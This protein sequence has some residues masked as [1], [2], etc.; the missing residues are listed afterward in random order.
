[1][2]SR[3]LRRVVI[4]SGVALFLASAACHQRA[5]APDSSNWSPG[6]WGPNDAGPPA[7]LEGSILVGRR[8]IDLGI[9]IPSTPAAEDVAA[10]QEMA[11]NRLAGLTILT[12]P[13]HAELP[14]A[15]VFSPKIEMLPP[16]TLELIHSD[17]RGLR[18]GQAESI[19]SSRGLIAI[20]VS[21][22][23]D[24]TFTRLHQLQLLALDIAKA[25]GG[26]IWEEATREVYSV[27]EWQK[28]RVD[29]W[30]ED[31]PEVRRHIA[32]HY[33]DSRDGPG[34]NGRGRLVTLGM[35]KFG[36]PDLAVQAVRRSEVGNATRVIDGVAQL[37]VEGAK[38][39]P[40]GVLTFDLNAVKQQIARTALLG[41]SR[42]IANTVTLVPVPRE[43]GDADNRLVE[44]RFP[45]PPAPAAS[46]PPEATSAPA[47]STPTVDGG[48][49]R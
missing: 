26:A 33:D 41:V 10:A 38:L 19:A 39:D 32:L 30:E 5:P 31:R 8:A 16:P 29:G 47:P 46:G 13:E 40:G 45:V 23:D 44:V 2:A 4:L 9:Y 7:E 22:D 34:P 28:V 15:L 27:P 21:L 25:N 18:P 20:V 48:K 42:P 14:N 35:E 43:K 11:K 36:L 24:P 3:A 1:M 37:L 17:G 6:A 49:A 12:S